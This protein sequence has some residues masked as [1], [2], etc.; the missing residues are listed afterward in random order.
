MTGV[1]TCALPIFAAFV[2]YERIDARNHDFS[3]VVSGALLG[4]AIG[5]AIAQN[6][7]HKFL[8]MDVVP[9]VND[10]IAVGIGLSKRW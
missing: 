1:Q 6:N 9:V 8:G 5:H 7:K 10:E 2:G 3:D 4:M